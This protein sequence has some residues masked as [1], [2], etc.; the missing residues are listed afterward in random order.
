MDNRVQRERVYELVIG[1]PNVPATSLA[2][3]E[4]Q[5]FFEVRKSSDN[6]D[7]ANVGKVQV[8]NLSDSQLKLL[9]REYPTA[10]LSVGY[11]GGEGLKRLIVAEVLHHKTIKSGTERV[12]HLSIAQ[13][14]TGLN[15]TTLSASVPPGSK[16][17]DALEAIRKGFGFGEVPGYVYGNGVVD[18]ELLYGFPLSGSPKDM[19]N[20]LSRTYG[21]EWRIDD[22]TLY[23]NDLDKPQSENRANVTLVSR[24]TGLLEN[25]YYD[26]GD[27]KRVQKDPAKKSGVR[28]TML[29]DPEIIPGQT[30]K[31]EDTLIQGFFKVDKAVYSGNY[32]EN[33]WY[34]DITCSAVEKV[35]KT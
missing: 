18:K 12:T 23:V 6:T 33:K 4:H 17:R 25:A 32:R 22:N 34:A 15:H 24:D 5:I 3:T 13:N 2:L 27:S 30:I 19:L 20:K 7:Q 11:R 31:L 10:V 29:L 26:S 35:T 1:D 14:Y 28:F 8:Y 9:E 21:F 16:V